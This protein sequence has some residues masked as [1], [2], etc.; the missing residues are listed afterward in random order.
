M[1]QLSTTDRAAKTRRQIERVDEQLTREFSELPAHVVHREVAKVADGLL[2]NAH[3]SDHVAVLTGRFAAENLRAAATPASTWKHSTARAT[4]R[5]AVYS[6]G[7][8][9]GNVP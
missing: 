1:T 4:R 5:G 8:A 2:A 3:F 6:D 7:P 9:F